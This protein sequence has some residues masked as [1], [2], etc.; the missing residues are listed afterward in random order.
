M[1]KLPLR[2]LLAYLIVIATLLALWAAGETGILPLVSHQ[3][4][5]VFKVP[6]DPNAVTE[7]GLELDENGRPRTRGK[8]GDEFEEQLRRLAAEG[9]DGGDAAPN[10]GTA[11]PT[12][13][14]TPAPSARQGE[15]DDGLAGDDVRRIFSGLET[16]DGSKVED[17][18][19][20]GV[21]SRG[22]GGVGPLP[23]PEE[24]PSNERPWASGQA[25]GYTMLYAMQPE[26]R[27]VVES[28]IQTLL[29]ARIREMY[30]GVLIDGFFGPDFAYLKDVIRRL[31]SEE[32]SLKLVLYLSNGATMRKW[33]ERRFDSL[34]ARIDPEE[35]RQRIRREQFLRAQ[36]TAVAI[37]ARELFEYNESLNSANSN[38]AIVMLEDNLDA[39][40]YRSMR[41][42]AVQEIGSL[43]SFVRNPCLGCYKGNDDNTLGDP[44]EEHEYARFGVL[45]PGDAYAFDGEGFQ[46]PN[47]PGPGVSADTVLGM[48][49]S[50]VDKKLRYIGLWRHEWQGVIQGVPNKLPRERTFIAPTPDQE[51]FD[52][53]LLRLGL[54]K[55]TTSADQTDSDNPL[56]VQ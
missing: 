3:G 10:S 20:A 4:R 38:V 44:R 33:R 54:I 8:Q 34:Y 55:E 45:K 15:S 14:P 17:Y 6:V 50:A 19:L 53:R 11:T 24:T 1:S 9:S 43:A 49:K 5:E 2:R 36:F 46:Y 39:Q 30:I 56:G 42:L 52:I 13:T 26:A 29:S 35:F 47:S 16:P 21:V 22:G 37:K 41:D 23:T 27:P 51:A 7:G 25:R 40:A 28:Q 12:F 32:R 18:G 31:S 48:M